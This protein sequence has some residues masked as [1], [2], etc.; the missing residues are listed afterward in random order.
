MMSTRS[1]ALRCPSWRRKTLTIFSRLLER[2][3]P[4]GFS[5]L[6]S[7]KAVGRG[8]PRSLNAEGRAAAAGGG[9]VQILDLE[10]AASHGVDDID[11]SSL[12]IAD[13]DRVDEQPDAIRLEH[14]I[15]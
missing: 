8:R 13:A 11:F 7:G 14:L 12:E 1:S 3:P 5:L 9:R 4:S 2:L 15:R 6:K 10:S